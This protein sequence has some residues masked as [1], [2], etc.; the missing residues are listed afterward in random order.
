MDKNIKIQ[1]DKATLS[2]NP[3]LYDL[4][5]VYSTSYVFLDRAYIVL[6]GDPE[7][8]IIVKVKPKKDENIKELSYD[9]FNELINY[10]DYKK[11][12]ESTRKIRELILQRALATND[13]N[14]I[15]EDEFDRLLKELDDENNGS[16]ENDIIVPWEDDE[17]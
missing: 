6:D 2:I 10:S 9:F 4:E 15:E 3:K 13:P 1:Q 12:S 8:E 14:L 5:V 17:D 11:R 7:K 16:D